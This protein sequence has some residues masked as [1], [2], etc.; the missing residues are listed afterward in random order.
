MVMLI[1]M[2]CA[3][4]QESRL[5]PGA[6]S[7]SLVLSQPDCGL[8]CVTPDTTEG[9]FLFLLLACFVIIN[10][11]RHIVGLRGRYGVPGKWGSIGVNDVK[12]YKKLIKDD[13]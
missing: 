9:G 1:W 12:I 3:V 13:T 7:G 10:F 4:S 8:V 5:C 2:T 6:I 11:G